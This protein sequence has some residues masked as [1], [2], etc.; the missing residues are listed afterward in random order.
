VVSHAPVPVTVFAKGAFFAR[1]AIGQ[2]ACSVVGLDWNMDPAE[3]RELIPNKVLQG[4]LDPCVLYADYGQ[5]RAEVKRMFDAF[6]HQHY[7]ANLG[8][9]IYPDTDPDKARYFVDAVKEL[10]TV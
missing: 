7:I 9:G 2:L 4:N 1:H 8:H 5:I 10:G 6:G 3:S